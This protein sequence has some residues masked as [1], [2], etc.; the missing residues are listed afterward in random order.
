MKQTSEIG[1]FARAAAELG[2]KRPLRNPRL[3]QIVAGMR[4]GRVDSAEKE[5][6]A[7]IAKNKRDPDALFLM[8][9]ALYRQDRREEALEHLAKCLD[10]APDFA[11][12]RCEYAKQLGEMNRYAAALI[13]LDILLAEDPTN[14]LFRQMKA[15]VLGNIGDNAESTT[16]YEALANENPDRAE[17]WVSYGH[18]LRVSGSSKAAIEA[19]RGAI[20]IRPS[21]G[22][23]YWSL[24]NLKTFRFDPADIAAMHE[25]VVKA[26]LSP[27]DRA[28]FQFALGKAYEDAGDYKR[29]WE[30]YAIVNAAM[31]VHSTYNADAL[32]T[33]V[34]ANKALFTPDFFA[35]REG[36][37]SKA[38]DPMFV[39]G[40]PRSGS[41]LVE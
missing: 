1:A 18:A 37:G 30:Q 41:T 16:L 27:S 32:T 5:L 8:A 33:A 22:Q 35:S 9:R 31:R 10:V 13:E 39:L 19:Y 6:A 7:Y 29:S 34:T 20:A 26:D 15:G 4:E 17:C 40:R 14:P 38:P 11:A 25:E 23:A 2:K 21:C 28:G 12:A 3:R 36:W 24:A